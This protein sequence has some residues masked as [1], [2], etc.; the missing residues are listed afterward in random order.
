[1]KA[2]SYGNDISMIEKEWFVFGLEGKNRKKED[3]D[4]DDDDD[5]EEKKV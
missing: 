2:V 1:M 4:D 5:D 3:D